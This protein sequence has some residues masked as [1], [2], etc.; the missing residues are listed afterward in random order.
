M[1]IVFCVCA[2]CP[3]GCGCLFPCA[4][5]LLAS[6][7]LESLFFGSLL[8]PFP[9]GPAFSISLKNSEG[10]PELWVMHPPNPKSL[11]FSR[12]G[13]MYPY[14]PTKLK[15]GVA[16]L[17]YIFHS[18]LC[19]LSFGHLKCWTLFWL[20]EEERIV[21]S[22]LAD[23]LSSC[24]NFYPIFSFYV[25]AIDVLPGQSNLVMPERLI[26]F[27]FWIVKLRT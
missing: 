6:P 10:L 17:G 14:I 23:F 21:L 16:L 15:L 27:S 25:E 1:D 22:V 8:V 18:L 5:R 13:G 4:A 12:P 3:K 26:K 24:P 9:L 7:M 19:A 11:G 2:E 20:E